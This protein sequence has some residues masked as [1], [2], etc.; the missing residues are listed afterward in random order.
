MNKD[1]VESR[2]ERMRKKMAES[3]I[4]TVMIFS[5]ENRQ[6]LSGYTGKDG[7]YDESAGILVITGNELILACDPRYDRQAE[8]EAPMYSVVCYKKSLCEEIPG[9]LETVGAR[10][11]GVEDARLTVKDYNEITS[12]IEQNNLGI[13]ILFCNGLLKDLRIQK[14]DTEIALIRKALTVAETSFLQFKQT[15]RE[16]MTEKQA[17]WTLEKLMRE[18]GADSLS[19]DVIAASGSQSALPHAIPGEKTFR[20]GEPLLFDFGAKVDGYCSDTTR[21][22]I[23]GRTESQ[24]EEVYHTVFEAQK[25]GVAAIRP[26]AKAS[27]VDAAARTYIDSTKF[28]GKFAHSLG[29]G[30]GMAIHESPRLSRLDETILEKGMVVTVEP[31]IYIPDWGGIRLENMILVTEDGAEVLNQTGYNDYLIQ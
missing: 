9:I 5:D 6:Y 25:K 18:N 30:V 17:A 15:I 26:G 21:T 28:E 4:D 13:E 19:F 3:D 12:R 29:H 8:Q 24:F 22:L 7:S 23:M 31:G 2:I 10:R 20:A 11:V 14:D 1:I 27:D 16:G